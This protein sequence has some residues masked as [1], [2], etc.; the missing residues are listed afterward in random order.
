[1]SKRLFL[2]V[3]AIAVISAAGWLQA[4]EVPQT[5]A[6]ST[7]VPVTDLVG[8]VES[9]VKELEECVENEA[10]FAD[11]AEKI[12]RCAHSLAAVAL[13]MGLHDERTPLQKA[14]PAVIKAC[15]Q[16]SVAKD[17]AA[18]KAG[19]DGVKAALAASGD[20]A[21]LKWSKVASLRPLMVEV[22]LINIRMKRYIRR[23][24]K[25]APLLASES[26]AIV[27]IS[28]ASLANAD[29]TEAPDKVSEWHK[30]CVQMR[31]AAG[32]LNKA[33]HTKDE[34][35][36][37]AAMEALQKSCEDC[38]AVFHKTATTTE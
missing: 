9:Y 34:Q 35:A 3:V 5:P 28:Q 10:D 2:L 21:A 31:N 12:Q 18:A 22:P 27:A 7:L 30:Y 20:P 15:Q 25:G 36:A 37:N 8:Q 4:A 14:A 16:L 23:F 6:F 24:E 38:H 13:A 29:E 19:V 26:A 1:M 32:A 33:A 17:Y 11:Y